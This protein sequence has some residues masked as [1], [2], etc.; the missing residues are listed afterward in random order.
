MLIKCTF[1]PNRSSRDSAVST[2]GRFGKQLRP[3]DELSS[4][5]SSLVS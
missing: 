5:E 2:E 4:E 1:Q 3:K